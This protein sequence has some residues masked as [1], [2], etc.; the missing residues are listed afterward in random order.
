MR[1][2]LA[3]SLPQE[4][5]SV[6]I[7]RHIVRAAV[8]NLGVTSSCVHDIEVA[9]SEACTNVLQHADASDEYEVRLQVDDDRCV[10]RVVDVGTRPGRLRL[11]IPDDPPGG[12]VEHG[13]GLLVM[14]ALVDRVGFA[15]LDE[16]GTVVSL[17]KRLVYAEPP[18]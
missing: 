15:A 2:E 14:R 11:D 12:E 4:G 17:E 1:L 10:L 7:A 3:V 5:R 16:R 6:P 9:L 8:A 18:A 13:R